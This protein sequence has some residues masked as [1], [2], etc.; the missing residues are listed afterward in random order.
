[1]MNRRAGS[2]FAR[3][4]ATMPGDITPSSAPR[5]T[6]NLP[7]SLTSFIGRE[8]E[9]NEIALLSEKH[10]LVTILGAA[11]IGK[12]RLALQ[13]AQTLTGRYPDG[14]W[15]VELA[16]I[17]DP[18]LVPRIVSTAIGLRDEP[19]R[20]VVDMLCDYLREKSI[21]IV[22]D[23]CEHLVEACARLADQILRTG[24][25]VRMIASSREALDIPG[26]VTYHIP[27]LDVP[28][29]DPVPA[30]E[31]A[32]EVD[33]VRLF[34]DRAA[35][36]LPSFSVSRDNIA[37]IVKI[38]RHLD[39]IPLAIEL[40]AAKIKVLSVE[41]IEERLEDRFRLLTGRSRTTLERHQTLRAAID[42]SYNLLSADE[43]ALFRRLSVF[44]GGWSL[45]AAESVCGVEGLPDLL[46][47]LEQLINKS[48]VFTEESHAEVR[49]QMLE[50]IRQYAY[51]KLV[52]QGESQA[53][54]DRQLDFFLRLVEEAE[55]HLIRTEQLTWVKNTWTRIMKICVPPWNGR[56][57]RSHPSLHYVCVRLWDVSG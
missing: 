26:E 54:H 57:I 24:L 7:V 48:L 42:W 43:Q 50:T 1:M 17:H 11:G 23:N 14:V 49:Y 47:L 13:I 55:P 5:R 56:C 35:A 30:W 45:R 38:C 21:L 12:T 36:A 20:P 31:F 9:S 4:L 27:P 39:G 10:P 18:L 29:S 22:L 34:L 41:Q 28:E 40:A 16:P 6:S 51:E 2:A 25:F 46:E 53:Q 33:A 37:S 15:L 8:K 32:S 52:Q 3:G 19:Q 44:I